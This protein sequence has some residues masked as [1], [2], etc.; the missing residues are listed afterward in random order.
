M[1]KSL[2]LFIVFYF[3]AC[4]QQNKETMN[5]QKDIYSIGSEIKHFDSEPQYGAYISTNDC[6]FDILYI[7]FL[8]AV[9]VLEQL[10]YQ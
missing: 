5:P 4:G 6:S 8:E 3:I 10:L 7:N 2:F 9:E 1:K